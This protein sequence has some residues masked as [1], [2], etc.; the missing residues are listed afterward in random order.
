MFQHWIDWES[1]IFVRVRTPS[2]RF[3][4]EGSRGA[5][6]FARI[7]FGRLPGVREELCYSGFPFF[8][9]FPCPCD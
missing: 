1:Q 3:A 6:G 5:K 8:S 9:P 4:S 7:L 2:G